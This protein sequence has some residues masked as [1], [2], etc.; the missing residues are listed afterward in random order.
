MQFLLKKKNPGE[1]QNYLHMLIRIWIDGMLR[2]FLQISLF[3]T[4]DTFHTPNEK[5]WN[6][7]VSIFNIFFPP[8]SI[9]SLQNLHA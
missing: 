6:K 9:I 5:R 2:L 8:P 3:A 4:I 1:S 7:F